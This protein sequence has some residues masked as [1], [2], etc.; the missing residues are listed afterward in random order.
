MYVACVFVGVIAFVLLSPLNSLSQEPPKANGQQG[1]ISG[2]V[3]DQTGAVIPG[4]KVVLASATEKG[5]E[6]Q[7][8]DRGAYSFKGLNP[9]TYTLSVTAPN[10]AV[11]SL[12]N[13]N[14]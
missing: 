13:I 5:L 4:A 10:F 12:T 14:L 8:D 9:G 2:A 1:S 7:T 6:T 3:M 11:Q